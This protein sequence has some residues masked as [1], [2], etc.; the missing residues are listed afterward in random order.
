M[1]DEADPEPKPKSFGNISDDHWS[2]SRKG[3]NEEAM[4][5]LRERSHA[6][7]VA[8]GGGS[9]NHYCLECHGVLPLAYDQRKPA[10]AKQ[11]E[12]CPHCGAEL[13]PRVRAMFNWV[14]IDQPPGSDLSALLPL[15][16]IALIAV[17]GLTLG[18][19]YFFG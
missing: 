1:T 14:E 17:V 19:L 16:L 2:R 12:H 18:A 11:L 9:R 7:G 3:L 5:H 6:P 13:D 10:D 15:I 4:Q 8:E